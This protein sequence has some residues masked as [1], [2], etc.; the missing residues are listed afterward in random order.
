MREG[1]ENPGALAPDLRHLLPVAPVPSLG[2]H[3]AVAGRQGC[4]DVSRA[5]LSVLRGGRMLCCRRWASELSVFTLSR[6]ASGV[7]MVPAGT[8]LGKELSWGGGGDGQ[9]EDAALDQTTAQ[10]TRAGMRAGSPPRAVLW[11]PRE[12]C[13]CWAS[14]GARLWVG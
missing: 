14:P 12:S 4:W 2:G 10:K 11:V 5:H 6:S 9:S 13:G 3:P 1:S 7:S 8:I